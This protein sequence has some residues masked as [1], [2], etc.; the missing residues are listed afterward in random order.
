VNGLDPGKDARAAAGIPVVPAFDGYR[1]VAIFGIA[2]F[3]ICL[4]SGVAGIVGD[5]WRGVALFGALPQVP[6]TV[7][8]I[9]SG[10]VLFLPT[11][12]RDGEFGG[13]APYALR[14]AA[15]ILPAYYLSLV[16]ALVLLAVLDLPQG[17]PDAGEVLAH[18][19]MLQTPATLFDGDFALGFGI[20][21]SVWTLSVETVF[22]IGLPLVA[23]AWYRRPW[24]GLALAALLLIGWRVLATHIGDLGAGDAAQGRF[25]DFYASQFPSWG[26]SFAA[27]MTGAWAYVRLRRGF[28]PATLAGRAA[29]VAAAATGL[30]VVLVVIAGREA[31]DDPNFLVGLFGRQ[32]LGVALALPLALASAMV[33]LGLCSRRAQLPFANRPVRALGDI[34]YGVYLIHLAVIAVVLDQLSLSR[35]GSLGALAA[36]TAIVIPISLLYAFGSAELVE[37]PLRRLVRRRGPGITPAS[38]RVRI[39]ESAASVSIVIPTFNREAWLAGALDSVLQQDH[40]NLEAVVV[41]DG[42]SDGTP[43]LLARYAKRWPEHRFRHLRQDNAGQATALNRGNAAA[44]GDLLGY[45]SDDDA[46]LPGAVSRLASELADPGVAVAYPGYREVD[47]QGSVIDTIRPVE[48]SSKRALLLHD[49]VI[50]PGG[51]ARRSALERAG[52]WDPSLRWLG[53]LVLWMGVGLSGRAVRVAEPLALWRRHPESATVQLSPEHAR[54]HLRCVELGAGLDAMPPLSRAE[55]AEALRNACVFAALFGGGADWPRDRFVAFDLHRRRI[56]AATSKLGP[57]GSIDWAAAE[58]SAALYRELVG[59]VAPPAATAG[60]GGLERAT[61]I[62][63]AAGALPGTEPGAANADAPLAPALIEAAFACGADIAPADARFVIVDRT[64]AKLDDADVSELERLG[65]GCSA[66]ELAE[67]IARRRG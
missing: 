21:A 19:T 8:F 48:Y 66:G 45:L 47:G 37:R 55:R 58:R 18:L 40:P 31:V 1:A 64:A 34:S 20:V 15:R 54:E 56:S 27:G 43:R 13:V 67:A 36:W 22:Y 33:S 51:I 52:G 42:S 2:F 39:D 63:A 38:P 25:D 46:L 6:L 10:F 30:A 50:G 65:F 11:A 28:D 3:H 41:D 17:L 60:A 26:L 4:F 35:D 61:G 53:D 62:L 16:I 44:R 32:S 5:S 12:E 24:A 29:P 9:V 57:D 49:T 7:L 23:G 14:R 59:L